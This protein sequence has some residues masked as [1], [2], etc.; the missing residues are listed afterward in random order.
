MGKYRKRTKAHIASPIAQNTNLLNSFSIKSFFNLFHD[1]FLF[2]QFFIFGRGRSKQKDAPRCAGYCGQ[3][4]ASPD[5]IKLSTAKPRVYI[6]IAPLALARHM[7]SCLSRHFLKIS[8]NHH[9]FIVEICQPRMGENRPNFNE[10]REPSNGKQFGCDHTPNFFWAGPLPGRN[11]GGTREAYLMTR[12]NKLSKYSL[13]LSQSVK[14]Y[15]EVSR[16]R[17]VFSGQGH[18]PGPMEGFA[19]PENN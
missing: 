18:L 3:K 1:C 9:K 7:L 17:A 16:E 15:R 14:K 10:F 4:K 6:V 13:L 2:Y 8:I 11:R 19:G 5:R 12:G